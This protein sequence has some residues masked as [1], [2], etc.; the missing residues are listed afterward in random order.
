MRPNTHRQPPI[1]LV[2]SVW[3]ERVQGGAAPYAAFPQEWGMRRAEWRLGPSFAGQ[4]ALR[5]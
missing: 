4:V 5:D 1:V 2:V 3:D